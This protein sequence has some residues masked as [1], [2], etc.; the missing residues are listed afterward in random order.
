MNRPGRRVREDLLN[1]P[2]GPTLVSLTGP[3][4]LAILSTSFSALVDSWF[5]GRLGSRELSVLGFT[6]PVILVL[7]NLAMGLGVGT[8]SVLA[9]ALGGGSTERVRPLVAHNLEL[10]VALSVAVGGLGMLTIG[11]LFRQLGATEE[12]LPL[13]RSYMAVWYLGLPV[14]FVALIANSAVRSTGETRVSA[15]ALIVTAILGALIDPLLIFGWGPFP[16]LE[17]V[18][19]A[20]AALIARTAGLGVSVWFLLRERMVGWK[21]SESRLRSWSAVLT[22]AVP[23]TV[24][25]LAF[26][27]SMLVITG[28]VASYGP[29]AVA[30]LGLVNRIET[31]LMVVVVGL[32]TALLPFVGQNWGAGR[33]D[34]VR[35]AIRLS[36]RAAMAWGGGIFLVMVLAAPAV[37]SLFSK[38]PAVTRVAAGYLW[39]VSLSYGFQGISTVMASAFNAVNRPLASSAI[40]LA[41]MF[42]LYIPL[43]W[44]GSTFWGLT[45]VF[46]GASTA[47]VLTGVGAWIW[48]SRTFAPDQSGRVST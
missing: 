1:G 40:T 30:A 24:S 4:V 17:V 42:A 45:G 8:A 12:V 43:A 15:S 35:E 10:G 19:A 34:R 2:V 16:R 33:V 37:A 27:V 5:V 13:L 18:G 3:M 6:Y 39:I 36:A 25:R 38:D 22:V 23:A 26:P 14:L 32:A 31:L 20:W 21:A 11:P 7:T 48:G 44:L 47:S 46:V 9:R 41:R 29:K 28:M